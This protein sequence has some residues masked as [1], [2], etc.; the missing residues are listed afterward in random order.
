M[1]LEV[2]TLANA[3]HPSVEHFFPTP[4]RDLFHEPQVQRALHGD[5]WYSVLVTN[6]QDA[7][8][9]V[10][11]PRQIPDT[12][13]SDIDPF[14]GYHGPL[15]T[16]SNAGFNESALQEHSAVCASL[17]IIAELMRFNPLLRNAEVFAPLSSMSVVPVKSVVIC[18]CM[19]S[20]EEQLALY[21]Q[22]SRRRLRKPSDLRFKWLEIPGRVDEFAPFYVDSLRRVGAGH[23]W[24]FTQETLKR[25][26]GLDCCRVAA[27]TRGDSWVTASLILEHPLQAYYFLAANSADH[28]PGAGE[29]L[30][31]QVNLELVRRGIGH[32][33]L[34]GGNSTDE[35]DSLLHFKRKF[36]RK[37]YVLHLGKK[38]HVPKAY[39]ALCKEYEMV[40][41]LSARRDYFLKY[42]LLPR[43]A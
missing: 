22:D 11:A 43:Y 13:W 15:T 25:L 7:F 21:D 8:F 38:V 16:T 42:R 18:D 23:R 12:E 40:T 10:F 34:G 29:R 35:K 9:H 2:H 14:L 41:E 26:V 31:H 28:V 20:E 1:S 27:V 33:M 19:N 36:S 39:E 17:K 3:I 6:G 4:K 24:Y 32:L 5:R 37:N 30:I